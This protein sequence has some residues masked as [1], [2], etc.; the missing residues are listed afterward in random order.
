MAFC[1]TSFAL[2][3]AAA[4]A[5]VRMALVSQ[6]NFLPLPAPLTLATPHTPGVAPH[7]L[8]QSWLRGLGSMS[9]ASD[10]MAS[11]APPQ[12]QAPLLVQLAPTDP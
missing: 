11:H 7:P 12:L 10:L 6:S 8:L 5:A 9:D 4:V 3:T 1:A 2:V